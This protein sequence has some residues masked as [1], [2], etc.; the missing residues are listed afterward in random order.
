MDIN[1]LHLGNLQRNGDTSMNKTI[2]HINQ[3][4]VVILGYNNREG[5]REGGRKVTTEI[6]MIQSV[7]TGRM[8]FLLSLFF[9][10]SK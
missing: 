5:R 4:T 6:I 2:M 8:S 3:K 10:F 1:D 9:S 7:D